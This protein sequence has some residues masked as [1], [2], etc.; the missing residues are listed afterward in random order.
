MKDWSEGYASPEKLH[1]SRPPLSDKGRKAMQG[2]DTNAYTAAK[3]E[4]NAT[5]FRHYYRDRGRMSEAAARVTAG[6]EAIDLNVAAKEVG[7]FRGNYYPTFDISSPYEISSVKTSWNIHGELDENALNR[8]V[9]HFEIM[10]NKKRLQ[11]R[12]NDILRLRDAGTTVPTELENANE[13]QTISYMRDKTLFRVPDNHQ[14]PIQERFRQMAQDGLISHEQA[15]N[16]CRRV[17]GIGMTSTELDK[18]LGTKYG[19]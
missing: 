11:A 2:F 6:D 17:R 18:L 8:Y 19:T 15:D 4:L 3:N 16:R 12:A 1:D 13:Q 5:D 10:T 9:R 7:G 14:K